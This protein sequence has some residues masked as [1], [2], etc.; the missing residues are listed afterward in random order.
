MAG[1]CRALQICWKNLSANIAAME[2]CRG[3]QSCLPH[4]MPGAICLIHMWTES[5]RGIQPCPGKSFDASFFIRQLQKSFRG[6]LFVIRNRFSGILNV[7]C[8][9]PFWTVCHIEFHFLAFFESLEAIH[10]DC[11]KV[12]EQIFTTIVRCNETEAFGVVEPLNST[13]CHNNLSNVLAASL[14]E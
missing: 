4:A 7:G 8:L 1:K 2:V 14:D 10:L 6:F 11:G 9:F 5:A 12:S 13:C 3:A